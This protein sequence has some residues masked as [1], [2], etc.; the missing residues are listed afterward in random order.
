M[1][2]GELE[3]KIMDILWLKG[4]SLSVRA[5]T[6]SLNRSSKKPYAYTTVMTILTRLFVKRIVTRT[7]HDRGFVYTAAQTRSDFFRTMSQNILEQLATH[8]GETAVAHFVDGIE[9]VDPE[10]LKKWRMMINKRS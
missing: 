1:F 3:K 9:H 10:Q 6:E 5:V 8:F 2:L 4:E 7:R